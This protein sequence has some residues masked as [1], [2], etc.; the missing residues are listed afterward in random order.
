MSQE[1][2]KVE[3]FGKKV[4]VATKDGTE[5]NGDLLIAA[6]G[7]RSSV[8]RELWRIADSEHP[9]YIPKRD[10]TGRSYSLISCRVTS[11]N[12]SSFQA[13][14]STYTAL[15]GLAY[16]VPGISRTE[17]VRAYNDHRSYFFQEGR[18]GTGEFYWWLCV[19]NDEK[20]KAN[21][22]RVTP[23]VKQ[24][25]VE[26]YKTDK[27]WTN[28]TFD[29]LYKKSVYSTVIPLEEFVLEKCFYKN[30]LLT[31]DSFRKLHPVAGQ[32]ANSAFEESALIADLLWELRER[33]DLH[34]PTRFH[35]AFLDFQKKRFTRLTALLENANLVQRIESLDNGVLKFMALN[36]IPR[37]SFAVTFMP[38]LG[39][40]F[41]AA[42]IMKH[43]PSP[44][45]GTWPFKPEIKVKPGPRPV[46]ATGLWITVL[47]L[48]ASVSWWI[49]K[50]IPADVRDNTRM[51]DS[52]SRPLQ[53][54][55]SLISV[56]I[57]GLWVTESYRAD[58]LLS[59][60]GRYASPVPLLF[61]VPIPQLIFTT[62][63]LAFHLHIQHLGLVNQ[64]PHLPM[65]PRPPQ[66]RDLLLLHAPHHDL[67]PR[68]KIPPSSTSHSLHSSN[69][70]IPQHRSYKN[71]LFLGSS[72]LRPPCH[73]IHGK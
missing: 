48:A 14:K 73:H 21:I 61:Y 51:D 6:D 13:I 59:P 26:K 31:G 2:V 29:D 46:L 55:S 32:G 3:I 15:V 27:I 37:L 23:E 41:A 38:Q 9:G 56:A 4:R 24:A 33:K 57:N 28:L 16:G 64:P 36:I 45:M 42:D 35:K 12:M 8:R 54:Y 67:P 58:S 52:L 18:E 44:K 7:V 43:L 69:P 20:L 19:K 11:A 47:L 50:Y 49:P 25:L 70:P 60:L 72:A 71:L 1:V 39:A 34:D 62:Q 63:C 5:F 53:L 10:K 17:S 40:S 30:I 22:R 68:R 66:P 65:S